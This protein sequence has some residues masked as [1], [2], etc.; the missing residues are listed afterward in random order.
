MHNGF[1]NLT[2][3]IVSNMSYFIWNTERIA[4]AGQQIELIFCYVN[5][6][7]YYITFLAM[8]MILVNAQGRVS[9]RLHDR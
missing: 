5:S 9:F 3:Q 8:L 1:V 6:I 7:M 2:K 4:V